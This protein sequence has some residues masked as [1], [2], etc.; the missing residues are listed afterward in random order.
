MTPERVR[1][2]SIAFAEAGDLH[3]A[4]VLAHIL[5]D[6]TALDSWERERAI[7]DGADSLG[8][9]FAK[10]RAAARVMVQR[11]HK[12]E[13]MTPEVRRERR[14]LLKLVR[15]LR[16]QWRARMNAIPR[17]RRHEFEA[18]ARH[19]LAVGDVLRLLRLPPRRRS[20]RQRSK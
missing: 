11:R 18:A 19:L 2:I 15:Q 6:A 9:R 17:R 14:R 4:A 8:D 13:A 10:L 20:T 1:A 16:D 5:G 3:V 7:V 12:V